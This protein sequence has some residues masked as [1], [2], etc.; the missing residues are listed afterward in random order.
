[1]HLEEKI[2]LKVKNRVNEQI[3][4]RE[5]RV[6]SDSGEQL[7]IV[8]LEEAMEMARDRGLDL[9]E[10]SD[11]SNPP[12]AKIIDF[13]KFRYEK[14]KS[15]KENKKK[16]KVVVVKE[17]KIRPQIDQHDLLIKKKRVQDFISEDKK[18][19]VILVL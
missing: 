4:S 8:P 13:G 1:M 2:S 3:R 12:V 19:K 11:K 15:Y 5:L 14:E 18:V 17:V 6:I 7:G 10:I 9:V 16:Q